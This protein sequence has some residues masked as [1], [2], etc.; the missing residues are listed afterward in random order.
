[1]NELQ[2]EMRSISCILEESV[3]PYHDYNETN[4]Y[5]L[6]SGGHRSSIISGVN[7]NFHSANNIINYDRSERA[8][9]MQIKRCYINNNIIQILIP[10]VCNYYKHNPE[11]SLWTKEYIITDYFENQKSLLSNLQDR[12][13][14]INVL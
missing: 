6:L 7:V 8:V 12:S 11:I 4:L 10:T 3:V 1:M 13:Q 9:E 2:L 5:Q 14:S